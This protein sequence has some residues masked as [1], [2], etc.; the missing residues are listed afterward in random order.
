LLNPICSIYPV[1]PL[2]CRDFFVYGE[3]CR[4]NQDPFVL[5]PHDVH[6]P[7]LEISRYVAL[8]FL[9]YQGFGLTS[10]DAKEKAF[11]NGLI[12]E[13]GSPLHRIEWVKFVRKA[14]SF[15]KRI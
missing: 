6:K 11:E 14:D 5:R 1:R 7:N 9:D 10:L 12:F 8:R 15:F 2:T 4:E 13:K 3:P